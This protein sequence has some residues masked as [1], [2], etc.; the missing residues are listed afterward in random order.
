MRDCAVHSP[1][2][3]VAPVRVPC[4]RGTS[5]GQSAGRLGVVAPAAGRPCCPLTAMGGVVTPVV[6]SATAGDVLESV[7]V[8]AV[9]DETDGAVAPQPVTGAAAMSSIATPTRAFPGR[10]RS[11]AFRAIALVR[12]GRTTRRSPARSSIMLVPTKEWAPGG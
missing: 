7:P 10:R 3:P 8:V 6:G 12:P 4:G 2:A 5:G 9:A 11:A 1:F